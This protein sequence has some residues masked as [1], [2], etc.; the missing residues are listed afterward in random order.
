[1][2]DSS[3]GGA[4]FSLNGP[5]SIATVSSNPVGDSLMISETYTAPTPA[6]AATTA[7][8]TATSVNT[9]SQTASVTINLNPALAITTASLPSGAVGTV[10]TATL[11]TTGGTPTIGWLITSGS[12][13]GL[14]LNST[15]GVLSGTPTTFGSFNIT[16]AATDSAST[17]V[18]VTQTYTVVI[19]PRPPTITTASL[20]N[21]VSGTAYS[22]Q[23][24]S[25]G[26]NGTAPTFA[27]SSGAL[28]A[29]IILSSGGLVSGTPTNAAAGAT[30][31]FA[32]TVT[33][34]TQ[35]S[36]PA[37]LTITIPALP[38]IT[39]TSL[40]SGNIG[41]VYSKQLT[42]TGGAGGTVSW[43]ITSG[44]LPA[45]SG[46]TLNTASGIISGT[47]TAATTYTFSVAVTVGTQTSAPQ[48]FTLVINSL[49]ITSGSTATGELS[50][51][52]VFRL[53]A[54]GGTA[55]YMW[56]LAAGSATLPAGLSLNTA[57]GLISGTPT[58][59]TGSPFSGIVVQATDSL[60]AT[61]T[62]VM[63]FTINAARSSASNSELKGQYALLL[64]GFD[65]TG[66]PVTSAGSFTADGNGNIIGG[67]I[68]NNG[69]G[70][71]TLAS[72][73][74]ITGG[75]Y[76]VGPDNRGK[77]LLTTAAGTSTYVLAL[78]SISS[79]VAGG[80]YLTEFDLSGQT[81]TGVLALQTPTAFALSSLTGGYAFGLEG[82]AVNSTATAL[83][84]RAVIGETQ[85]NGSGSIANAE[86]LSPGTGSATPV[87]PTSGTVAISSAA[88]GRGT[89]T[90]NY[91]L[92]SGATKADFVFYIV[93]AS[94]LFLVSS[95]AANGSTGTADLLS[96]QL[97]QQTITNG[98]FSSSSLGGISVVRS[99]KL[100][101]NTLGA[102]YPDVQVGL[103]NF[104]SST[105]KLT[106]ASDENAGGVITSDS[107]GGTFAVS[108]N[109]RVAVTLTAGFGGCVSCASPDTY[110]YLAGANQGFMLDF[111]SNVTAGYFEPQTTTTFNAAAFGGTYSEGS[112][113]PLVSA[114]T[115]AEASLTSNG[116]GSISGTVDINT[117]GTL[118][119]DNAL[120][121]TYIVGTTGRTPVTTT[122]SSP[123]L[124]IVSAT[125]AVAVDLSSANPV[126]QEI[127]H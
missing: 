86:F 55:P 126:V 127:V 67:S 107:L 80:G 25:T 22:Q 108:P 37:T 92:A 72:N 121:A 111:S 20:P 84:H 71:S 32:V 63:T 7:V 59:T 119:L 54:V 102:Y 18:T 44:S 113:H 39:T 47:P 105:G 27:L 98:N 60:A 1:V 103:F 42:C 53:T 110:F 120:A 23:L 46:L 65:P 40:P 117:S 81:P 56:S 19:A 58:T 38:A 30:Y 61:A 51:P 13:P 64:S 106:L 83:A 68:D 45:G 116:T 48:A 104:T 28:P 85:L 50:L 118:A 123:V 70:A 95:D 3:H 94:K 2:N 16:V 90:L 57:T 74:A 124:Y 91:T 24:T 69:T 49:L 66:K 112:L 43:A 76:A 11:T 4:T 5:G 41:I 109:G 88:N 78:N 93:N 89:L 34:G 17:K 52:F 75:S 21:A 122:G 114:V 9:P 36:V 31:T 62:Q 87:V 12:I 100:D 29:G 10:Y 26:G 6:T 96:G 82:F 125:K 79:G 15:T 33:V 99:Q 97:L 14:N 77:L 101:V 115:D 35:T 73:V 8:V